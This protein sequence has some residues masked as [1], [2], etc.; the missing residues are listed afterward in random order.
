MNQ[1]LRIDQVLE[2]KGRDPRSYHE[3]SYVV[4][5]LGREWKEVKRSELRL[6][7][8]FFVIRLVTILEV[9]TRR[10]VSWLID[11]DAKFVD[12]AL[13]L[14]KQVKPERTFFKFLQGQKLTL[15]DLAA[16]DLPV[17]S[18]SQVIAPI[19]TLLNRKLRPLLEDQREVQPFGGETRMGAQIIEDYDQMA[20]NLVRL[21]EVR[22]ILCHELPSRRVYD[23]SEVESFF[24]AVTAFISACEG[25]CTYRYTAKHLL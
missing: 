19:E 5:D 9:F 8:D 17:N 11:S 23:K 12:A 22:H 13:E 2:I 21:F 10:C 20:S 3:L 24:A 6:S 1:K 18:F 7:A 16:H 15:G 4:R 14:L 25:R